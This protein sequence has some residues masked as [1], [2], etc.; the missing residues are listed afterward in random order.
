MDIKNR[1]F[2]ALVRA[3]S[4]DVYRFAYWLCKRTDLAEDMTQETFARA[5]KSIDSLKDG[6]AAK[7]WLITILRREIA[8]H[9]TRKQLDTVSIDDIDTGLMDHH[10]Q[11]GEAEKLALHHALLMLDEKYKEPLLLQVLGGYS[12]QEIAEILS[13]TSN[14]VL[15]RVF[16]AR[17]MLRQT[18]NP[19]TESSNVVRL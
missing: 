10:H 11:L 12:S 18:L 2:E 3:Y 15:T 5:W 7:A 14:V 8:R 9:Y 1:E 19:D 17:Q 4:S 6:K 16:R 13:V